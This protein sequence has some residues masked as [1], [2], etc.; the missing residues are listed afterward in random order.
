MIDKKIIGTGLIVGILGLFLFLA[1][2]ATQ[3]KEIDIGEFR[4][5]EIVENHLPEYIIGWAMAACSGQYNYVPPAGYKRTSCERTYE[6]GTHGGC[7]DCIMSKVR[8]D[9]T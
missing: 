6:L 2:K 3:K 7:P 9:K 8:C 4:F 1:K 5:T